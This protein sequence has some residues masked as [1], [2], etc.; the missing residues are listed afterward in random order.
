MPAEVVQQVNR[1][2]RRPLGLTTLEFSDREGM[3]LADEEI[4]HDDPSD[5]DD[6]DDDYNPD[7]DDDAMIAG[8]EP[9]DMEADAETVE[10]INEADAETVEQ[11]H[12]NN[13]A[14]LD[15]AN[16]LELEREI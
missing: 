1:L 9:E 3:P 15:N 13:L 14:I 7:A 8:V 2:S 12:N 6:N 10:Q 11:I 4:P 5:D 16:N